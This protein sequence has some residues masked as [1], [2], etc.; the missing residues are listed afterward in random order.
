MG[1]AGQGLLPMLSQDTVVAV[2]AAQ[3]VGGMSVPVTAVHERSIAVQAV[4]SLADMVG[5]P[6][7]ADVPP[8]T[9]ADTVFDQAPGV[10]PSMAR[11]I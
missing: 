4:E 9:V 1:G 10:P 8:G 5:L 3:I 6:V 7:G 2:P 11:T